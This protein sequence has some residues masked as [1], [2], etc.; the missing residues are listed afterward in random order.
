MNLMPQSKSLTQELRTSKSDGEMGEVIWQ[1]FIDTK[2]LYKLVYNLQL[3]ETLI[4]S[5]TDSEVF[6]VLFLR[7]FFVFLF[8]VCFR[9][10]VVLCDDIFSF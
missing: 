8:F 3:L 2:H 5:E 7:M 6:V 4:T 10:H 9:S 1:T